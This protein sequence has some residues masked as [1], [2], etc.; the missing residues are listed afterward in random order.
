MDKSVP[1]GAAILLDFIRQTESLTQKFF[2]HNST[3]RG[4]VS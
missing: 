4:A 1:P 3:L 2:R